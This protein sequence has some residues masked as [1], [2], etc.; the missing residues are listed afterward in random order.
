LLPLLRERLD[1]LRNI[2][3][4]HG[5]ILEWHPAEYFTGPYKVVANIPYYITGAI[6]RHLLKENPRPSRM[7]LTVQQEVARRIVAGPGKMSLLAVSVQFY[8]EASIAFTIKAG[9]FWP[10]PD[11]DSAVCD[12]RVR[13]ELPIEADQ[14]EQFFRIVRTGFSQ[15]RKQLRRNLRELGYP[16]Q[17]L[18]EALMKAGVDG[19]RRA[20]TLSVDDWLSVYRNLQGGDHSPAGD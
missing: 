3:V 16:E 15:K 5:D 19:K 13:P 10:R 18:T 4:V 7:T 8:A 2:E 12:L 17:M 20:E 1:D 6:L 9:A 11:V 14:V